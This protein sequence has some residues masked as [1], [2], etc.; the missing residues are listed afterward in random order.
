M[1]HPGIL[2]EYAPRLVAFEFTTPNTT[3]H[4]SNALLFIGGLTD[5]LLT[6]PYVQTLAS[7]LTSDSSPSPNTWSIFNVLLTTSYL[8][9]G[10]N[11][12][13]RDVEDIA[14]CVNYVRKLKGPDAKIVIMGHSTGSQDVL[15]Y[16]SAPNPVAYNP[17]VNGLKYITRPRVDGAIMQAPMS[18]RQ[19]LDTTLTNA[20]AVGAYEQLVGMARIAE[21]RTLLPLNLTGLVGLDPETPVNAWR[22]LSLAS[23]DSPEHPRQDDLFSSDL[24]DQRL[25]ETFGVVGER[26][27]LGYRLMTLYSGNDE[28]A[29]PGLDM[30]LMLKR[31][32]NAT[33]TG[34]GEV[35]WD[36]EGSAVIPGATHNV[37]DVG[38][39]ELVDRVR[40]YLARVL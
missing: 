21:P 8:G 27:L 15:H 16:L 6:V 39:A 34:A 33:N 11:S 4:S 20:E 2:H 10:I 36:A 38:Q 19:G 40:G 12:L 7:N 3:P 24:S 18:D 37:Q 28:Y 17:D 9:W 31:W 32:E 26:G 29:A 1:A 23:P 30:E 14:Q 22:F 35:K 25:L 5:G 13:D